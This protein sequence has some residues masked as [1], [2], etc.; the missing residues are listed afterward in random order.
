MK[1]DFTMEKVIEA[2]NNFMFPDT[3]AYVPKLG[4]PIGILKKS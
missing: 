3:S 1:Y 4:E 2:L